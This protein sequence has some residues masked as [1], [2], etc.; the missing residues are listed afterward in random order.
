MALREVC[1]TAGQIFEA[2]DAL[3]AIRGQDLK[4]QVDVAY[5]LHRIWMAVEDAEK[6]LIERIGQ[7]VGMDRDELTDEE[8][9]L[10]NVIMA[11]Q[12]RLDVPSVKVEELLSSGEVMLSMS[13][14]EAILPLLVK[15]EES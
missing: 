6:Y 13:D 7:T 15:D 4:F 9:A 11:A 12:I 2:S 10:T 5:R 1:L 8:I 14:I 3:E